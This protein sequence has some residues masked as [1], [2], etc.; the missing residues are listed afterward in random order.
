MDNT[1]IVINDVLT[2][3]ENKIMLSYFQKNLFSQFID[4]NIDTL[5]ENGLPLKKIL[6]KVNTYF[7]LSKMVGLEC[8]CH[9]NT[10]PGWHID[11]DDVHMFKTKELKTPICSIVYYAKIENLIGGNLVTDTDSYIP[12][13]NDVVT[14]APGVKHNVENFTGERI[15]IAL[16]PWDYKIEK[17]KLNKTLL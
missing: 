17:F 11:F 6:K 8:W 10:H 15:I 1:L 2:E 5:K 3:S 4:G 9:N 12:K 13:T 16:N 7:D 14:F